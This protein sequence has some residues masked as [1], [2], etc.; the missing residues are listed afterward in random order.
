MEI[1]FV[2]AGILILLLFLF[3][4]SARA[5]GAAGERK[6]KS[7]VT[8]SLGDEDRHLHDITIPT[9]NGTTQ[10]DHV[11]I[12]KAGV[13]V[14]ETKNMAGWI[15][16]NYQKSRWTQVLHRKKSQFQ[17]PLRQNFKHVKVLQEILDLDD[18]VFH[19]VVV[20]AGDATPKTPMPE[21]IIWGAKMLPAFINSKPA[22]CLSD[23]QVHQITCIIEDKSLDKGSKTDRQH[24]ANL[25]AE[26]ARRQN[27]MS[28]CPRCGGDLKVR[29]NRKTGEKFLGCTAY[30][31]CR[32]TRQIADS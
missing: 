16:G 9:K 32:G 15:F 10:I 23:A 8:A 22:E 6:V 19:N 27:D 11:V 25:T 13:F 20:F 26:T 1:G 5:K 18:N 17:N 14:I 12:T 7:R 31:K 3:P 21:N 2:L 29:K 28:V 4:Q 30:P 24:V